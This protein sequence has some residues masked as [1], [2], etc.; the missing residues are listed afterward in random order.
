MSTTSVRACVLLA[1]LAALGSCDPFKGT[2]FQDPASGEGEYFYTCAIR[3][4]GNIDGTWSKY[5][6]TPEARK[7]AAAQHTKD[8]GA[9]HTTSEY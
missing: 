9:A 3:H 7:A 2:P 6:K 4:H 5:F 1:T 8:W